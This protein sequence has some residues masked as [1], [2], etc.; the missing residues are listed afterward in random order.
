VPGP[1]A[2]S[3]SPYRGFVCTSHILSILTVC[4]CV[5]VCVMVDCSWC[6]VEN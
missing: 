3:P 5:C 1:N 2:S 4:V 6:G